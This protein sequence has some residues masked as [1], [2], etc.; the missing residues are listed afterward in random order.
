MLQT[1]AV[2]D[3]QPLHPY[4]PVRAENEKDFPVTMIMPSLSSSARAALLARLED[5]QAQRVQTALESIP[6]ENTCR[7]RWDCDP[8]TMRKHRIRLARRM[9]PGSHVSAMRPA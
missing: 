8:E 1:Q 4:R 2:H 9:L 7:D 5:L 3:L 6:P